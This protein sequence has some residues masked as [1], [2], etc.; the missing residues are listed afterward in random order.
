[1]DGLDLFKPALIMDTNQGN[2]IR[3]GGEKKFCHFSQ[4]HLM[5]LATLET[6]TLPS[7]KIKRAC[8]QAAFVPSTR[9]SYNNRN[10]RNNR[11]THSCNR[12]V[13]PDPQLGQGQYTDL[14]VVGG[15]DRMKN[16]FDTERYSFAGLI[17]FCGQ[18]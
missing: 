9:H 5:N 2:L 3:V 12:S 13:K 1:M 6:K 17:N 4:L 15:C 16:L 18:I 7:M 8:C 14:I 10:N 11:N